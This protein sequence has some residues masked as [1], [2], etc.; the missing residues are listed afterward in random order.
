MVYFVTKPRGLVEVVELD[1]VAII[2]LILKERQFC[3]YF[4]AFVGELSRNSSVD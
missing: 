2:C 4:P 1:F 3:H